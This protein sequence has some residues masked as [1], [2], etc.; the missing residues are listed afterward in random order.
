[1]YAEGGL[2]TL[3]A[4]NLFHDEAAFYTTLKPF[5]ELC[6][7]SS[8]MCNNNLSAAW[9]ETCSSFYQEFFTKGNHFNYTLFKPRLFALCKEQVPLCQPDGSE[10]FLFIYMVICLIGVLFFWIVCITD[11]A[12][13]H[14][15]EGSRNTVKYKGTDDPNSLVGMETNPND[16]T[17]LEKQ[18]SD[19]RQLSR[20]N[21]IS[22]EG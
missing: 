4:A 2:C 14:L 13:E 15:E 19:L 11:P 5:H 8:K 16:S 6:Y 12:D 22:T 1:M 17:N 9:N 10:K 3:V 7:L 21:Y 20:K 18:P